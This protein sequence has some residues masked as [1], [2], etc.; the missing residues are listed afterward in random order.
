MRTNVTFAASSAGSVAHFW[1][2]TRTARSSAPASPADSGISVSAYGKRM[3]TPSGSGLFIACFSTASS[4]AQN[5]TGS[6]GTAVANV[7]PVDGV[8]DGRRVDE[9]LVRVARVK[10]HAIRALKL[11]HDVAL[12][13]DP[14]G[15]ERGERHEVARIARRGC[16]LRRRHEI[17]RVAVQHERVAETGADA[18]GELRAQAG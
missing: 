5:I 11:D 12:P 17:E 3:A 8:D 10:D 6:R 7:V 4:S 13:E 15:E 2:N 14:V 18:V 9:V 1:M 16:V